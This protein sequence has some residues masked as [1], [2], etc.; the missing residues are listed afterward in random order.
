VKR[1]EISVP[2]MNDSFSKVVIDETE[3]LLRFTWSDTAQRWNFG[4]YTVFREPI[5]QGLKIV[6]K[7]PLNLQY[8]DERMPSGIFG[9]YTKL[10]N[11]GRRDFAEGRAIFAYIPYDEAAG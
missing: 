8:G 11:V 2:D 6:P 4:V 9:A 5:V 1:L 3:H 7:F 10:D